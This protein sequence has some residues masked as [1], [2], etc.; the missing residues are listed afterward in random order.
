MAAGSSKWAPALAV[1][2]DLGLAEVGSAWVMVA[3]LGWEMALAVAGSA[4]WEPALAVAWGLVKVG[5][6]L[7][8]VA[9]LGLETMAVG[10][11]PAQ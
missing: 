3:D 8:V 4:E 5:L 7:V 9:D 6:A 10:E 1:A 2:W 11:G